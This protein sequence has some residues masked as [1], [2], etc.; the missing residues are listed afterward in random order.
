[1]LFSEKIYLEL[2][3]IKRKLLDSKNRGS[4]FMK[5]KSVADVAYEILIKHKKPLHYRK[6]SEELIEIK[7]LK[8]KEPFYAVNASMSGD[9]RFVRV[10]R[11]I[12]GLLKWK[13]RDANIKYSV[14]S[15]CLKDGTMFLTSYMRPFFPKEKKVVEIIFIDKEGNEIEAKVNNEFS[16]ITGIDQWYKRKK[17]KVNDVIYIGLIDYDKRKYF[18][19]TEEETQIEP[20]EEIKEKIYAILKKEGKPLAY[21]EICERALDVELS[22][23]NLFS[24]Y[25]IDTLKE[26]PKFIEEKENIWGLFDWLSETKKLQKLLFE[27]KNS[28]KLKNTIKKIF[29]FLGFETSFIIK[30]KT[31]FIL[32]KAL[33]DYKSYSIII[34][35]KVSEEKNKKIEKYEQWDDL[36]TAKKENKADFSVIISND[37]NYDSLN[38]QSELQNVI[39]LESRWIDTIIKEHDRLTFSLSNLKKILSSDNSTESNIFQLLEKRNTTYNRIKLV[40]TMMD[41]LKKSSRKKLYLN[42]ESLT[43]II[44]QQDGELVNFE[45]IQEYEVEQIVNMLSMEPFNILQ[46][47][48][49]DNIILNYS[50]KLAKERL[51]KIIIEIF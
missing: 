25:I 43:K 49:M 6:I 19:V 26:N 5:H 48:E 51:D 14:T 10:K 4:K 39:L 2:Q 20:K 41:I 29:D 33:L 50:P 32:A 37:F 12:W 7:P 1:M 36:K 21:H 11:G 13:Y 45:K 44:N 27:S 18:L 9:K 46:K 24:D 30:G 47:T 31:S 8:M 34:D 16:Y 23:K 3:Y 17:I 35:G 42:I 22:E 38:M 40:N 28:E 15:Y